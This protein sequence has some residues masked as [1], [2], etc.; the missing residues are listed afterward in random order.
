[1]AKQSRCTTYEK[2]GI[3]LERKTQ[4]E[5]NKK[6]AFIKQIV[7]PLLV[8]ILINPIL[9]LSQG[10]MQHPPEEVQAK[11]LFTMPK[12]IEWPIGSG[13]EDTSK[14]FTISVIGDNPFQG[15]L[16][17]YGQKKVKN[18]QVRI[19]YIKK[20]EEI[21]ATNLLFISDIGRSE[22]QKVINY[23][24]DKP[25]LTMESTEGYIK[26]GTQI[27]LYADRTF[28][29]DVN[30]MALRQAGLVLSQELTTNTK[31][32]T[33]V[34]IVI[35]YNEYKEKAL[36]MVQIAQ[37][38][39]WTNVPGIQQYEEFTISVLGSNPFGKNLI[40]QFEDIKIANKRIV[41][42]TISAVEGATGSQILFI[43]KAK[44]SDLA[45][46]LSFTRNKPIL[47]ISD[48]P[49]MARDGIHVS[50]TFEGVKLREEVNPMAASD[51][52]LTIGGTLLR[53][54]IKVRSR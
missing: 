35:P 1:M 51:A 30:E 16:D 21:G 10:K 44:S 5:R 37:S 9:V 52:G 46:I 2:N 48:S 11:I 12:Y 13:V 15:F 25:I 26:R 41:I 36:H 28:S 24:K 27:H 19:Q 8:L 4:M 40:D 54:G 34:K 43:P 20:A 49:G 17:L 6:I 29:M 31:I 18:K 32:S 33:K 3:E 42:R 39:Q 22:F 14:P 53:D 50:F 47:T 7:F 23:V 45:N 38:I